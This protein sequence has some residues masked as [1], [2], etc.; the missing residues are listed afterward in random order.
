MN[1]QG[2]LRE[3][4]LAD[5]LRILDHGQRTGRLH[6]DTPVLHGELVWQT[7]ALIHAVL[8]NLHGPEAVYPWLIWPE[9]R[10]AFTEGES[11]ETATIQATVAD[12]LGEGLLR[13][14][15]WS[16]VSDLAPGWGPDSR[17]AW[18]GEPDGVLPLA[19]GGASASE[20]VM[21]AGGTTVSLALGLAER[22]ASR[23]VHLEPTPAG[24]LHRWFSRLTAEIYSGFS[25]ISGF[26]L[27]AE[28]DR[29]L[30]AAIEGRGW[31][32]AWSGGKITD[33][34]PFARTAEEQISIYEAF[35]DELA[36]FIIPVYGQTLLRQATER[37]GEPSGTLA[38][39][40]K[41]RWLK[42]AIVT[43]KADDPSC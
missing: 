27:I 25:A 9:G 19:P 14:E 38:Q 10:F 24:S 6:I 15:A 40:L 7:G 30:Q 39:S 36:G 5:L 8:G 16:R 13:Q 4:S 37:A 28:L 21:A 2:D 32:L 29:H 43:A 33:K 35:L 1:L 34:I 31:N 17:A 42:L 3:F 22:L 12:I 18:C 23:A 11:A 20:L 41:Q 26:K